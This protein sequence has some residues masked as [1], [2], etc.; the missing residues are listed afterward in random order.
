MRC[1]KFEIWF[2]DLPCLKFPCN[3]I[4]DLSTVIVDLHDAVCSAEVCLKPSETFKEL[5]SDKVPQGNICCDLALY[6][7][8][9][10]KRKQLDL[11]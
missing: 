4:C 9:E 1:P 11:F 5:L 10:L 6:T 8:T 2:Y 3:F 7:Q